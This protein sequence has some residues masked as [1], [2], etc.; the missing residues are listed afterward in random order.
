MTQFRRSIIAGLAMI[1]MC[2]GYA[3]AQADNKDTARDERQQIIK[4]TWG[5]CVRTKWQD[6]QD[7]CA[8]PPPPAPPVAKAP[9]PPPPPKIMLDQR[10]IYFDFDSAALTPESI[11]KLDALVNI[12]NGSKR[13]LSAG[14][15]GYADQMGKEDYNVKLSQRRAAAVEQYLAS[16][17]K[18]NT[19][20]L[21][22]RGLGET[23]SVTSCD[24]VKGRNDKIAC[25]AKDRRVE[26]EFKYQ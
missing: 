9:P 11:S 7:D 24:S 17:T 2:A 16:R 3:P 13:I 21:A 6:T 26:V 23:N 22:T 8:P 5:N 1:A 4:N 25:L 14:A 20:V 18:I 15:V 10:T 19:E 12:I